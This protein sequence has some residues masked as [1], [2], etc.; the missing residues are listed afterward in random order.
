MDDP[1]DSLAAT[2]PP[3]PDT[4]P[5]MESLDVIRMFSY[6][7]PTEC[8]CG[9]D[10]DSSASKNIPVVR[11]ACECVYHFHCLVRYIKYELG[12]RDKHVGKTGILCPRAKISCQWKAQLHDE[13]MLSTL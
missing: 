5:N 11:L 10:I 3:V 12:D 8:F 4:F 13:K 2:A 7:G 9:E 6:C 1:A